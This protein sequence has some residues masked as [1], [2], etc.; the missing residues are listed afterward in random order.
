MADGD[1]VGGNKTNLL[2]PPASKKFTKADYPTFGGAKKGGDNT[3]KVVKA[4]RGPNY[5][6]LAAKK[7]FNYLRHMFTQAPIVQYFDSEWHV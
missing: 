1:E 2:N 3:Q 6:T 4:G 7:T 5:L